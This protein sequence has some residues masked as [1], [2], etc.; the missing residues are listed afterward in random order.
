MPKPH[1]QPFFRASTHSYYVKL[2]GKF[3]PLGKDREAAFAKYYALMA[4]QQPITF[5]ATVE[6]LL[7]K[8]LS[9]CEL[10]RERATYEWY[11]D[12]LSSFRKSI[13]KL[14][15]AD[16]R[17]HHVTEWLD[18]RYRGRSDNYRHGACRAIARCFN[19]AAK[20][21]HIP[22][23][24]VKG[25]EKPRP[26]G[27]VIYL[28]PAQWEAILAK[29]KDSDP[30]KDYLRLLRATGCRPQEAKALEARH[31]DRLNAQWAFPIKESKGKRES[32]IVPL[33]DEAFAI[34][35]RLALKYPE[36]KLLRNAKGFAWTTFSVTNRFARL[37]EQLGFKV[38][39]YA[40]RHT[41]ITDALL[42]GVDPVT[43]AYI[44]GHKD[45]TMILKIYQH[46]NLNK[47]HVR[48]A[49]ALATGEVPAKK[50][51]TA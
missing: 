25:V 24:P 46:L 30:F 28:T 36:G 15:L 16:L 33:N 26:H 31:F 9:W 50:A 23:N 3:I 11:V 32:R 40:V 48:A 13:G 35:S 41:F 42:R 2:R 29:V 37:S 21:G 22:A 8:F 38:F 10:H 4:N 45:A 7:G 1:P 43:L 18:T 19:W 49:L 44:V 39:A 17:V 51:V 34:T 27:R 6:S 5:D 47:G 12:F 14:K 20:Q